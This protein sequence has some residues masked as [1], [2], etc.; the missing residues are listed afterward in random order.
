MSGGPAA[1]SAPVATAADERDGED[2]LFESWRRRVRLETSLEARAAVIGTEDAVHGTSVE[3][4]AMAYR[5]WSSSGDLEGAPADHVWSSV[6]AVAIMRRSLA[7]ARAHDRRGNDPGESRADS[8][9]RIDALAAL[10][11]ETWGAFLMVFLQADLHGRLGRGRLDGQE[12][13]L[14]RLLSPVTAL[15]TGRQAVGVATEA[16]A[17]A[18]AD[19]CAEP[20]ELPRL[21]QHALALAMREGPGEV[22]ALEALLAGALH[23]GLAALMGRVSA[24]L[25]GLE[26][27]R[28]IA[29][30][31]Q[32]VAALERAA[33]WLESGKDREVLQAGTRRL[34][35][36]LARGLQLAL[37]CEHAQWMLDRDGDRRGCAAALRH[38]RLPV[39]LV[40]EVDPELD[41]LLLARPN[42]RS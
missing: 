25:R 24:C 7:G 30:G 39:D 33:L 13:A 40:H 9:A 37:L 22:L 20:G 8:H 23:D 10:E 31:R 5:A 27:P 17:L 15:A 6:S 34:A 1:S 2:P 4:F 32:S 19:A 16:L 12:R 29:A 26:E 35:L 42:A 18:G 36:T 38:S 41:L 28:L 14:L 11:A 3:R 21:L